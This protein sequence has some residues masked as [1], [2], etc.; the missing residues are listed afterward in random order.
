MKLEDPNRRSF[1]SKYS[2]SEQRRESGMVCE[3]RTKQSVGF[4]KLTGATRWVGFF[5][6]FF[7]RI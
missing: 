1:L 5:F 3:V 2:E 6:F 7:A 4:I